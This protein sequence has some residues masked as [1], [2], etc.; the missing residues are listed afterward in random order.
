MALILDSLFTSTVDQSAS[1]Y[2]HMM[3]VTYCKTNIIS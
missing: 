1:T 3:G 2:Y